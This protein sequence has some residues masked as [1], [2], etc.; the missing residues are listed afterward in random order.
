MNVEVWKHPHSC[1]RSS[2]NNR[3]GAHQTRS[4]HVANISPWPC[5]HS[6]ALGVEWPADVFSVKVSLGST[7]GL[8]CEHLVAQSL[9]GSVKPP[10]TNQRALWAAWY[11]LRQFIMSGTFCHHMFVLI[12]SSPAG[13]QWKMR[14]GVAGPKPP[15]QAA[16]PGPSAELRTQATSPAPYPSGGRA[17]W[18]IAEQKV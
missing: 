13:W 4:S 10:S 15:A 6:A 18:L 8:R 17:S 16:A 3:R 14:Y 12:S 7:H 1:W 11:W 2:V 5:L 9:R